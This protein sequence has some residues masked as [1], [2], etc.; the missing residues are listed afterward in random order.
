MGKTN[1]VTSKK[2]L[3]VKKI[4]AVSWGW[5][6]SSDTRTFDVKPHYQDWP[7]LTVNNFMN[8]KE[9]NVV[10]VNNNIDTASI[11]YINMSYNPGNGI[12]TVTVGLSAG[13]GGIARC[14]VPIY[15]IFLGGG[16]ANYLTKIK[17]FFLKKKGVI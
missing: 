10:S 7:K 16:V 2:D 17:N 13:A 5:I 3:Q 12:L 11:G 9:L 14:T 15:L 8:L 6:G 1:A 4:G